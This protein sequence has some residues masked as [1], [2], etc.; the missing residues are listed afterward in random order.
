MN[1]EIG[2]VAAQFLFWEYF[3]SKLQLEAYENAESNCN[4]LYNCNGPDPAQVKNP[5]LADKGPCRLEYILPKQTIFNPVSYR[6]EY[7]STQSEF[8]SLKSRPSSLPPT[9]YIEVLFYSISFLKDWSKVLSC[10]D[11]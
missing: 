3:F 10:L 5:A 7:V 4:L 1:V 11:H 8:Q 2:T 6:Q 9:V